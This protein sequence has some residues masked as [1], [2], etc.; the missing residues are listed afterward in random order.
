MTKAG[1]KPPAFDAG[2]FGIEVMT[3]HFGMALF[4]PHLGCGNGFSENNK[5]E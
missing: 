2:R 1:G 4:S 5:K 3:G